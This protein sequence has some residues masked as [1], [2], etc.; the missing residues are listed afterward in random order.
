M[1]TQAALPVRP[2]S[3]THRYHVRDLSVYILTLAGFLRWQSWSGEGGITNSEV[4]IITVSLRL[5]G[6][7]KPIRSVESEVQGDL[8]RERALKRIG[9]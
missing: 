4:R 1:I 9:F 8:A 7:E 3:L 6:K 5:P 2:V